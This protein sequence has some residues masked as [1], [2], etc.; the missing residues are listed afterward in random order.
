M[1]RL[2]ILFGLFTA[3]YC[4]AQDIKDAESLIIS[5]RFDDAL[6]A[7]ENIK[8]AE[9]QNPYVYF[10]MGEA[11]LKSYQSD[12]YS[13]SKNNV[14][15]KSTTCFQEGIAKDSLNPLNYV[16]LGMIEL[17]RNNDTLKADA[18]FSKAF[19]LLPHKSSGALLLKRKKY[20]DVQIKALVKIQTAE[21]Y[22]A[23]PRYYKSEELGKTILA[24]CPENPE[25]YIANGDMLLAQNKASE[26][27]AQ[28]KKALYLRNDALTNVMVARIYY[29]ARNTEEA[30]NYYQGALNV[31]SLFAPAYKGLGDVFYKERKIK[32]AKENYARFLELTGNNIPAK[33]SY[34]KALYKA[35]DFESTIDIANDILKVDSS[36]NYIYRLVAYS[37]A[38]KDKPEYEKALEYL[39]KFMAKAKAEDILTKDY[40]YYSKIYLGLKRDSNDIR[41]GVEMLEKAYLADTTSAESLVELIKTAYSNRVYDIAIKYLSKKINGGDNTPGNY[42]LLGKGFYYNKEYSKSDSIF[43]IIVTKDSTY[44]DAYL[45]SAYSLSSLDPDLKEGLAKPAFEKLVDATSANAEKYKKERFEAFSY[46]GSYY[47]FSKEAD[48]NKAIDQIKKGLEVDNTN[49]TWQLKGYYTLAF[50]YYKAKQWQNAKE[51]YETILKLKPD[52]TNAPKA[53]KDI[54]K[55][56]TTQ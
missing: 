53:L 36:K 18:Y 17:F 26:A 20:N 16:G 50:A 37:F 15:K 2:V 44:I 27:I 46:L 56:L 9:P 21:L 39:N 48:L 10:D 38:D 7:L 33:I 30:K 1:R 45:W 49:A 5:E 24:I 34:I 41:Q 11:I 55:Y 12:P 3:V 8:K 22:S 19:K 25:I 6:T 40:S 43:K 47:M 54:N 23:T 51:A 29:M 13:D 28:Y 4:N 52:D 14:L 35:K 32:Q 42:M 31:D